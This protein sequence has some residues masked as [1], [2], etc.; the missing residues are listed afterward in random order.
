M[1]NIW[2]GEFELEALASGAIRVLS[3]KE[4]SKKYTGEPVFKGL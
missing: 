2:P 3:N 4:P 1:M